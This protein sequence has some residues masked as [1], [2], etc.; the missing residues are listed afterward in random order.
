M[1]EIARFEYQM[2]MDLLAMMSGSIDPALHGSPLESERGFDC[3]DRAA[4]R[5]QRQHQ[6]DGRFGGASPI[7]RG[8]FAGAESLLADLAAV[9]LGLARVDLDVTLGALPGCRTGGIGTEYGMRVHEVLSGL[10]VGRILLGPASDC[11]N[12]TVK[13]TPTG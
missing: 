13:R 5:H 1:P 8:A 2:L 12:L 10:V 7:Q 6:D 3:G 11:P 9:S 4:M